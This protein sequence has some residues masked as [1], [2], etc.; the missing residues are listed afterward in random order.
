QYEEM[1][2]A[3]SR[4][5]AMDLAEGTSNAG[6]NYDE[7]YGRVKTY[8]EA[9]ENGLI[10]TDDFKAWTSYLDVYG[11]DTV[12]AYDAVAEK[13]DRYFTEDASEGLGNFLTDMEQLGYAAQDADGYWT[14]AADDYDVA[15]KDMQMGSEWF[16]DTM[17][18]LEDYGMVH[19][20]V[21]SLNEAQLKT[22]DVE[23]QIA[24][25]V[26]TYSDMV[27]RGA[28]DEDL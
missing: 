1:Q 27:A 11:R 7:N 3:L 17:R 10:G 12:E 5:A 16:M 19:T 21:S 4:N 20:Y 26:Q 8:K 13:I 6:A 24:D 15:A 22:R 9:R 25:A 2:K 18:K 28:S 23:E 14:I